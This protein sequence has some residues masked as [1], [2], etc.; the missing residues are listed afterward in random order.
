MV[1]LQEWADFEEKK[2]TVTT[3]ELDKLAKVYQE[4][5]EEYERA[6]EISGN[7]YKEAEELEGKFVEALQL[8]GKSKYY[9]EGIGTFSFMDKMSIRIPK[10]IEDKKK[11]FKYIL[12]THGEIF[13]W[14][15]V[16][17]NS[18]TLNKL[19]NEDL[20]TAETRGVDASLFHIPGLDQP[21]NMRSLKLTKEKK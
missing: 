17:V 20:K 7:L 8:A 16:S 9:V 18:A 3:E 12:D 4:K 11:L 5:Y 14:D 19:Y 15:K 2:S 6:K 10:T 13:Y 21:T 1:N